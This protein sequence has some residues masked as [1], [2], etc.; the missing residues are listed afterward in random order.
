MPQRRQKPRCLCGV[1]LQSSRRVG[2]TIKAMSEDPGSLH[3][4]DSV[5]LFALPNV[6]LFPHAVLPLHIFEER[7]K[8]MTTDV[9]GGHRQIAMALLK[10][11]WEKDY[12]GRPEVEPIVCVGTILSHERLSDGRYNFLL[13]GHSRAKVV[14]EL[15]REPYREAKL[16]RLLETDSAET[17]LCDARQRLIEM[18]ANDCYATMNGGGQIRE[19]LAREIP[20]AVV[21]DMLA[22]RVLTD[23]QVELK[24]SLLSESNIKK[25]VWRTVEAMAALRPAWRNVP[26][27]AGLN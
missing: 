2:A 23:D 24:Q 17:D 8:Q 13:Q 3:L 21:A 20:T 10:P 11:G 26:M 6:V 14:R 4:P 16:E 5:P 19:M 27:D 7:Y 15:S 22:F 1:I 25:R 12:Y 9:L 18:F